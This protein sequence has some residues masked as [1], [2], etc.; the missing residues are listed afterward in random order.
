MR[1]ENTKR[2]CGGVEAWTGRTDKSNHHLQQDVLISTTAVAHPQLPTPLM[3][4]NTTQSFV[5]A[6]EPNALCSLSLSSSSWK[7]HIL[8]RNIIQSQPALVNGRRDGS[9]SGQNRRAG[10]QIFCLYMIEEEP[11]VGLFTGSR[12]VLWGDMKDWIGALTLVEAQLIMPAFV[13]DCQGCF[14]PLPNTQ[15]L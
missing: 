4:S 8:G 12:D 14:K 1:V 6:P 15:L 10:S 11:P 9:H 2:Q 7:I 13:P 3:I 5:L